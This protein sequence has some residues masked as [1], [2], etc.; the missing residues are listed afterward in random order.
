M[1]GHSST[2]FSPYQGGYPGSS[3]TPPS[4]PGQHAVG[5][6]Y[7]GIQVNQGALNGGYSSFHNQRLSLIHISEPHET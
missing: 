1:Y 4:Y 5:R 3:Q 7:S 2:G 6:G